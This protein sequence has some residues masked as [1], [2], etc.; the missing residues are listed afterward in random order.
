MCSEKVFGPEIPPDSN[1]TRQKRC[2]VISPISSTNSEIRE[3][4]D[5]VF[6]FIIK[7][8]AER[9]GYF[10]HRGD[11]SAKPGKITDQMFDAI[12][13]D[14]LIVAILTYQNPNVFFE[15][16]VAQSAA[17]PVILMLLHGVDVPFDIKDHR[18]IYY[19]LRPRPLFKG[20]YTDQLY[21]SLREI[22][23]DTNLRVPFAPG[24]SPLG[25]DAASLTLTPRQ[26]DF[27]TEDYVQ[28]LERSSKFLL[29]CG[30]SLQAWHKRANH[31]EILLNRVSAGCIVRVLIMDESNPALEKMLN[32]YA[33]L[34]MVQREIVESR[35]QW[36]LLAEKSEAI[37]VATASSGIVFQQS[38]INETG[39][40]YTPYLYSVATGDC[41]AFQAPEA[42]PLYRAQTLEFERLWQANSSKP[43][44]YRP[45]N[46]A[47]VDQTASHAAV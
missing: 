35:G 19:D 34:D 20:K 41:P 10:P 42:S 11:H 13:E 14:D 30:I 29:L 43:I 1:T 4:A 33:P 26:N 21:R 38:T 46:L 22:E 8:A 3:H 45:S 5:D 12:F 15:L 23:T 2:F 44:G 28:F 18:V 39:V 25:S 36:L 7:P 17:R 6:D 40:L 32:E 9:A 16:A 31:T 24:K 27:S 37:E 47:S